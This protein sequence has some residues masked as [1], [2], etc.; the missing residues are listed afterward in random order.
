MRMILLSFFFCGLSFF[1]LSASA[2]DP[3]SQ[4]AMAAQQ[5][6]QEANAQS[7][8][9][10]QQAQQANQQAS[11]DLQNA[12]A[13]N[14][15]GVPTAAR[16]RL[17]VKPGVYGGSLTVAI[18][19]STSGAAI[20]YTTDGWTPTVRSARYVG[21]LTINVTTRLRAIA[22]APKLANSQ[23]S[24]ADYVLPASS[25]PNAVLAPDGVLRQGTL[26]PLVFASDLNSKTA[27]VG[28][29]FTLKMASEIK[30]GNRVIAP[31]GVQGRGTVTAV[32]RTRAAGQPGSV[33]FAVNALIV[34][35]TL[36]PLTGGETE[37]GRDHVSRAKALFMVPGMEWAVALHGR[38]AEIPPGTPVSAVVAADTLLPEG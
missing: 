4:A 9:A 27:K 8:Q 15:V 29:Q 6:A 31:G 26:V 19:D 23:P 16:P 38:D 13:S 11:Q 18:T 21:P 36:I 37:E 34:D 3:A 20:Y 17:S 10:M 7:Q 22:V 30:I 12:A 25:G 35:G 28:D 1:E 14:S 2:Q 5:A 24:D 32:K 33:T